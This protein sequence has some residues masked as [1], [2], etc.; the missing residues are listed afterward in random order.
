MNEEELLRQAASVPTFYFDGFGAFRKI[1]GVLRCAGFV[2]GSG[3]QLNLI[4]SLNGAE[5]A[6]AAAKKALDSDEVSD[7]RN[8]ERSRLAH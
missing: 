2:I 7:L 6:I 4:V 3:A 5:A 1:N 8:M